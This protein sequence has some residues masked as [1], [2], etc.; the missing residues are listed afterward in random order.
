MA[1]CEVCKN[2]Y[3]KGF[4][5]NLN[6][7]IHTFDCFECA[8]FNLAPSCSNYGCVIIGHGIEANNKFYCCAC[9]AHCA[10]SAGITS[11]KDHV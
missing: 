5:I 4:D 6:G 1:I 10:R 9:C 2:N 7:K 3:E 8:I 11:A